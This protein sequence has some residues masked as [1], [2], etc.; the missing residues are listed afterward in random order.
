[1]NRTILVLDAEPIVRSVVTKILERDGYSVHAV[2]DLNAALKLVKECTPDMLLTNLYV[3]GTTGHEAA[4]LLRDHC[5][6]MRVLMVAGLPDDKRICDRAA[7]EEFELFPKPFRADELA[8]K[9]REVLSKE[10]S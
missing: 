2:G 8:A 9:V 4:K 5:P 1:M 10:R 3:P 6:N 7:E